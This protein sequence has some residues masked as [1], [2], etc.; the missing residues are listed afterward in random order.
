MTFTDCLQH[1]EHLYGDWLLEELPS[2]LRRNG[3]NHYY[4]SI[5]PS[6]GEMRLCKTGES[7]NYPQIVTN[8]YVHIPFCSG[9]CSFCSYFL[10]VVSPRDAALLVDYTDLVIRDIELHARHA[11]LDIG[12][13]YFG[14]GTPS[15]L[16]P[17]DFNRLLS[18]LRSLG[19]V[20]DGFLGTVEVHPELFEDE[21]RAISFLEVLQKG[22]IHRISIGFQVAKNEILNGTNRRH[23]EECLDRALLRARKSMFS[24][25]IDLMYGLPGQSIQDWYE[26]LTLA[27]EHSPDS[28]STYFTFVDPGTLLYQ[29]LA[30]GDVRQPTFTE[31]HKQRIIAQLVLEEAGYYELPNDFWWKVPAD[32]SHREFSPS[33]PSDSHTLPIGPGSYGFFC[34][35]QFANVFSFREYQARLSTGV[36][37]VWRR[38][39]L[40][41]AQ[42]LR[43]DVMFS[44]KNAPYLDSEL[45][46]RRYRVDIFGEFE[47]ELELLVSLGLLEREKGVLRVTRKGSLC[48]EEM[49]CMFRDPKIK[50]ASAPGGEEQRL[51]RFNFA[52]TYGR[53]A[54]CGSIRNL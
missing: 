53:S 27:L 35:T 19:I 50:Y 41:E 47:R 33:L 18:S 37:R 6:I 52:P 16:A 4:L 39:A 13:L 44:L 49:A 31:A 14:G 24:V 51:Q 26:T 40:S 43:R 9:A 1:A 12:H 23:G 3:T 34:P 21:D 54:D 29:E 22:G 15:L 28:I 36:S 8:L 17:A 32:E 38:Y 5:Y 45:F 30:R 48:V 2:Y 42:L 25:N 11:T 46:K 20:R 7:L 10:K